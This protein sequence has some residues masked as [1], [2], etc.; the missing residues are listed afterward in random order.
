MTAIE[1]EC[2]S[3]A[4][5]FRPGRT[6]IAANVLIERKIPHQAASAGCRRI[7]TVPKQGGF[8]R[9]AGHSAL[10]VPGG[11]TSMMDVRSRADEVVLAA[12]LVSNVLPLIDNPVLHERRE[13]Q[14]FLGVPDPES[15][16]IL[17]GKGQPLVIEPVVDL[18]D[19]VVS[20]TY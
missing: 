5:D 2:C 15:T 4:F 18:E 17:A 3:R 7:A 13:G 1:R 16:E 6:R 8:R 9:D 10:Q 11:P 20:S 12:G 14:E 19:T